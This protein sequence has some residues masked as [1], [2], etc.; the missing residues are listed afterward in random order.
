MRTGGDGGCH[1]T[2]PQQLKPHF[3]PAEEKIHRDDDTNF[4][5]PSGE[6]L[7]GKVRQGHVNWGY[8]KDVLHEVNKYQRDPSLLF[9]ISPSGPFLSLYL[10]KWCRKGGDGERVVYTSQLETDRTFYNP[11]CPAC[12]KME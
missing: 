5:F 1:S 11:Q 2:W 6:Q 4:A 8:M 3:P 12:E 9:L 7:F 10:F